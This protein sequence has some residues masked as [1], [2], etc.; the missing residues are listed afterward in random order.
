MFSRIDPHNFLG[1]VFTLGEND[2]IP[3]MAIAGYKFSLY[4]LILVIQILLEI[5]LFHLWLKYMDLKFFI[6][7]SNLFTFC[8]LCSYVL[9]AF[10]IL[11]HDLFL[12][13]PVL[14]FFDQCHWRFVN[15]VSLFKDHF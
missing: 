7:F 9:F 11:M 6:I 5:C 2:S 10:L 1:Q 3:L 13:V 15:F 14:F 8:L 4:A 12:L